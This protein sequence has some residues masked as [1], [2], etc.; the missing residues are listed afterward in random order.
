MKKLIF[1]L[2]MYFSLSISNAQDP[3]IQQMVNNIN[4]DSLWSYISFM[5]SQDRHC[6]SDDSTCRHWLFEYF[7]QLGFDTVYYHQFN[8]NYM[9]NVVAELTGEVFPDSICILGG[10]Y[11]TYAHNA[12]G[13]D[14]NASGTAGVLEVA[15]AISSYHFK[16][17]IRFICFSAEEVG[18]VGSYAYAQDATNNGENIFAMINL[19][20]ISHS[21]YGNEAP[22]FWVSFNSNSLGLLDR[23][24]TVIQTY[25]PSAS[26][27]DGS[28]TPYASASDHA[29]FWAFGIPAI[30]IIDCLDFA[31]PHYNNKIHSFNDTIGASTNNK[32]LAQAC[33]Q[34]STALMAEL[35][36]LYSPVDIPQIQN[37]PAFRFYPNPVVES[38]LI[39][40]EK[41]IRQI[42]I[43]NSVGQVVKQLNIQGNKHI[44]VDCNTLVSGFY[45]LQMVDNEGFLYSG[46]FVKK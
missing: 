39:N 17:T 26:W 1:L 32:V 25:V 37:I 5:S 36:V 20:M 31:S 45:F 3:Q 22:E 34:T 44:T 23:M 14:D 43:C 30:F 46:S 7:T 40:S 2:V 28:T 4:A 18:L 10:H 15:R 8:S 9:P 33:V 6:T 29:S 13:A 11:D 38:V 19:D 35:A 12:P 27:N 24:D 41:E 21:Q 16:K 42:I